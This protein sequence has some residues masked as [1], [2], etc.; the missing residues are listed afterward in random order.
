MAP[1][2]TQGFTKPSSIRRLGTLCRQSSLTASGDS[3][4]RT[5]QSA[6]A[7]LRGCFF[8]Q[9]G[10]P[11]VATHAVKQGRRYRYY[12]SRSLQH[13]GDAKANE[14]MRIPARDIEALVHNQLASLLANTVGLLGQAGLRLPP[15]EQLTRM[16]AKGDR[17]AKAMRGDGDSITSITMPD[18]AAMVERIIVGSDEITIAT[19]VPTLLVVLGYPPDQPQ[20][21]SPT[22]STSINGSLKRNGMAMRMVLSDGTAAA[23]S[24]PDQTLIRT[25]ARALRWWQRL[26][27]EPELT[28]TS[29]A[30]AEGVTP[31]YLTRVLRLVFLDPVIIQMILDGSAPASLTAK[32]LTLPG[33]I[34]IRWQ[35]QRRTMG[36]GPRR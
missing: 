19:R 14:G 28:P 20:P 5:A 3:A 1:S 4:S 13:G 10:E 7:R 16:L 26:S 8:D 9:S 17:V 36:I 30:D 32:R 25:I 31:S 12:V 29:L 24:Q 11:L 22:L 2:A 27:S 23:A 34:A 21:T 15:P 33:A 6:Q 18:I 35:E